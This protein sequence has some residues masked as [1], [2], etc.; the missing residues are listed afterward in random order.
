LKRLAERYPVLTYIALCYAI[1]WGVWFSIPLVAGGK[2]TLI[3]ILIGVGIGPG[4]AAVIL[5][6]VR[7]T[8]GPIRWP[9]FTVV[10]L[11]VAA[12]NVWSLLTGDAATAADL[13]ARQPIGLTPIGIAGAL[14]AAAVCGFVFGAAAGSR[15]ET[16]HS[17]ARWH[18]PVRWWLIAALLIPALLA[19]SVPVTQLMGEEIDFTR[20]PWWWI[21]R[22]ILFTLLVVGIGE[23]TGWRGWMLPELQ[24]RFSPLKSSILLG[25]TWGLWHLPLW[26][27]GAYPGEPDAVV[28][29]LFICPLLAILFT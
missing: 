27:I 20:G 3:K 16:L 5:D 23:E 15:T 22:S 26:I 29:Y 2:W 9:H 24:K 21:V 12:L 28:E 4:L 10:F 14:L 18:V 19:V 1:T 13:A 17:I 25:L 8:A 6:R 11:A 7:G